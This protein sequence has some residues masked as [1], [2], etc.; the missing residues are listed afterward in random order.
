MA[1]R[2]DHD[3]NREITRTVKNYNAKIRRMANRGIIDLPD[4]LLVSELKQNIQDRKALKRELARLQAFSRL[5]GET[6]Q[7]AYG[8]ARVDR[9]IA[10]RY[11]AR[12]RQALGNLEREIEAIR[13]SQEYGTFK[14]DYLMNLEYRRDQLK[15]S[16][17]G[18]SLRQI[19]RRIAI[20]NRDYDAKLKAEQF[21]DQF[22]QNLFAVAYLANVDRNLILKAQ[23]MLRQ[24]EPGELAYLQHNSPVFKMFLD[25]TSDI[26]NAPANPD[27]IDEL[28]E[29]IKNMQKF[30]ENRGG[31]K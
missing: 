10:E 15:M 26:M 1:I 5:H 6:G 24:V 16:P 9:I 7:V 28:T 31:N 17:R 25:I 13:P 12:D 11:R 14:S 23:D 18:L 30:L 27:F 29:N 2:Y 3:F 20:A 21:Y 19:E 22:F 4:R 8:E